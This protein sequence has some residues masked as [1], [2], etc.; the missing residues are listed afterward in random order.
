MFTKDIGIDLGT[1][2]TLV[3][4][5]GR[6]IIMREPSVV[7]VDPRSDELR[8]RSVGHEAKA[9]I[10]RAPGSI[11]AVR[12]LKDG[13]IADFDVTAA[14]LQSFIRQ[15]CGNS[16]LARPRVV[17]CVPSGVTEVER[18]AVRQAAAKAGARQVTVIEEPMAAAIGA[19]LPIEDPT[20]SMVVD[21]G[22]GTTEVAVIAMGGIVVSQSIRI[23]GDE[24]DQ[25]I[26]EHVRDAY[27]L[28]IGER[29]AEDIKI[30]VGSA[31][32][33]A[34]ELD[35]EVNG[36][37]VMS[38]LPKSVRIESEE[39]RRAL[40]KPLDEVT[41]A[42][43]DALDVTPPDL[44]SDLMYYGVLLTGGGGMLRGL[45][46]RLREETGVPVNVSATALENVV[47]GCA[48]VLEAN[49]LSGGFVQSAS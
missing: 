36:R 19:D 43:K 17:I 39:I 21:I 49:A 14:M 11:V 47:N 46:Q 15:A 40:D 26:L 9:V 44:A 22:G 37:D 13:V 35:V 31:A 38:G 48:K 8:V 12:P 3:Y 18:R 32:P 41:K 45:D 10:G 1:A 20:G 24:F 29:T 4:M 16:I 5:K 42:V 7:A 30:K 34:E 6:G 23:A 2:N 27:N 28:S 25:T 33:L